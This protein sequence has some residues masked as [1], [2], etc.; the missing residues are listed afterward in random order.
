[1]SL[2]PRQQL[3]KNIALLLGGGMI[4]VELDAEH[5]NLAI[6]K[7]FAKYRQRSSNA[8]QESFVFLDVQPGVQTYTLPSDVQIVREILRRSVGGGATGA[9]FDPFSAAFANNIYLLQNQG[10]LGSG[11]AGS[12]ATYDFAMQYQELIARMFG[13][14]VQFT[15]DASSKRLT[16]HRNFAAGEEVAVH[17][18]VQTSEDALLVDPYAK[19]WLT[20]CALAYAKHMLGEARSKFQSL[21]G[22]QGGV[23]MNG[24]TLKSE[25]TT[26]LAT[27]EQELKDGVDAS[28]G[29]GFTIG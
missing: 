21:A 10:G 7:A 25:A 2:T 14:D 11:G 15:F 28:I 22:P 8:F 3:E 20:D 6:D 4:D 29:Y 1:M 18:Y 24:E 16:V 17:C 13:R 26:E 12:L 5:Y 9:Q 23:S 19:P 27:L